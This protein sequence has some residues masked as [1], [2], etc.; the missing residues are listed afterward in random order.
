VEIKYQHTADAWFQLR[1]LYSPVV[2]QALG[3]AWRLA[4]LEVVKWFDPAAFF[5]E[6]IALCPDPLQPPVG[7]IGV[8]IWCP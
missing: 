4:L 6:R 1:E 7:R 2:A 5:P 8:H 3:P